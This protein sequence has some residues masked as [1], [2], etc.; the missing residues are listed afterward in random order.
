[1]KK[2]VS[3]K[4]SGW[5]MRVRMNSSRG[6]PD[7]FSTTRPSMSDERLYDLRACR[8]ENGQTRPSNGNPD[9][10]VEAV[11]RETREETAWAF[12]PDALVGT[13]L[14]RSPVDGRSF[15]RFAFCGTVDDH[16]AQQP[17][18]EGILRAPW[19]TH[20]QLLAQPSRLRSPMV[21][22]CLQDYLLGKRQALDTVACLGRESA[23]QMDAVVNL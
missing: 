12:R 4:P 5:V 23:L 21:L 11:I 3:F 15:L 16:H 6:M 9:A 1:M 22:R 17:L 20:E 7:A 10:Q 19:M 13:Y 8:C 2:R 18:D 14:W